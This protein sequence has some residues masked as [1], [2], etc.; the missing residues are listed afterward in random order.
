MPHVYYITWIESQSLPIWFPERS[1]LSV[2]MFYN[3][4]QCCT[5]SRCSYIW[6]KTR[7]IASATQLKQQ[8]VSSGFVL[9]THQA[10]YH[11]FVVYVG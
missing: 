2:W 1:I 5:I 7:D 10:K 11:H 4:Y 3:T 8:T 9:L 6:L